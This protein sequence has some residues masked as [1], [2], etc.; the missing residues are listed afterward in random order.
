MSEAPDVCR[1][2]RVHQ[3]KKN[4][5]SPHKTPCHFQLSLQRALS[6]FFFFFFL[7]PEP[8]SSQGIAVAQQKHLFSS[9]LFAFS[10]SLHH[11]LHTL[12]RF[13]PSP[14]FLRER[15]CASARHNAPTKK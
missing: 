4:T 14:S 10:P 5:P 15:A 3:K 8:L 6:S 2:R 12:T 13:N 1:L 7:S 11:Q 9:L